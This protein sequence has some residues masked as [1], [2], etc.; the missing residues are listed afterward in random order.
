MNFSQADSDIIFHLERVSPD[1][2]E[3]KF[4]S[5]NGGYMR[6]DS[7]GNA[8]P[9]HGASANDW[10]GTFILVPASQR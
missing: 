3:V 4:T 8:L 9:L 7:K 10:E 1:S 6:F 2:I 5:P